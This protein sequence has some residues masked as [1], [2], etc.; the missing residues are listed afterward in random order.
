MVLTVGQKGKF[1][2]KLASFEKTGERTRF[3]GEFF[4]TFLI[5]NTD[6]DPNALWKQIRE[7]FTSE[8]AGTNLKEGQIA[9]VISADQSWRRSSGVALENTIKATFNP[10][11]EE[12]KIT[13]FTGEE[14]MQM[15]GNDTLDNDKE[16]IRDIRECIKGKDFDLFICL[17]GGGEKYKCFG[18][19]QIKTSI[20]DRLNMNTRPSREMMERNFWSCV[21]C[22][23]TDNFLSL[24]KFDSMAKNHWHG[25]YVIS[26][27]TGNNGTIFYFKLSNGNS[28]FIKHAKEISRMWDSQARIRLTPSW[29]PSAD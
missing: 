28:K 2:R 18:L 13:I 23:D 14:I 5:E 9:A 26:D 29:R 6:T 22:L 7:L 15:I 24:P 27:K 8:R 17:R 3:I 12:Y 16:D 25:F 10:L 1:L 4:S 19:M 21:I 11:L 20:R